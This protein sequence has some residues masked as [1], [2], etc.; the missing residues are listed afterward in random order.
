MFKRTPYIGITGFMKHGE[1]LEVGKVFPASS[2]DRK[3]ATA[4]TWMVSIA[5]GLFAGTLPMIEPIIAEFPD[6]C[7]DAEG[8]L[9]DE[10]DNLD[11]SKAKAYAQKA[12]EM[13]TVYRP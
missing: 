9:R 12:L 3:N 5:G 2:K 11:S 8:R 4:P 6:L 10:H 7:I 13:Y 1:L